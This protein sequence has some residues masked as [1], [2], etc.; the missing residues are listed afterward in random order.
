MFSETRELSQAEQEV[1]RRGQ[2]A[3]MDGITG[4]GG[5]RLCCSNNPQTSV[6]N[7]RKVH[8][9]LILLSI[10]GGRGPLFI[11]ARQGPRLMEA[12]FNMASAIRDPLPDPLILTQK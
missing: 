6:L 10:G 11:R 9:L 1:R 2:G 12:Q 5:V 4:G 7:N 8:F 3:E